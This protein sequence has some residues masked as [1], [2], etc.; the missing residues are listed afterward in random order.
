MDLEDIERSMVDCKRTMNDRAQPLSR[1]Q[2]ASAEYDR[3]A[4]LRRVDP[5]LAHQIAEYRLAGMTDLADSLQ[6]TLEMIEAM[7]LLK[8]AEARL[9]KANYG[10]ERRDAEHFIAKAEKRLAKLEVQKDERTTKT[11]CPVKA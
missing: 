7:D 3:L 4:G 11:V 10:Y 8:A 5:P 2:C 9:E 1:R 6:A